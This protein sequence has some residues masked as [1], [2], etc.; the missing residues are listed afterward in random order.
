MEASYAR[1]DTSADDLSRYEPTRN[2]HTAPPC[3]RGR[4]DAAALTPHWRG[5]EGRQ[6][7]H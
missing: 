5:R 1:P 2:D 3:R 7:N 6:T 4:D